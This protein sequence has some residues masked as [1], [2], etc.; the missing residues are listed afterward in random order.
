LRDE[1]WKKAHHNNKVVSERLLF[2][3]LKVVLEYLQSRN[4]HSS[5][6]AQQVK[7]AIHQSKPSKM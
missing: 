1:S 5:S 7:E 2:Q 6:K 4:L 3:L